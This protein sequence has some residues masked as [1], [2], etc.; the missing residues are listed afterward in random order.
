MSNTTWGVVKDGIIIPDTA[1]PEGTR[2]EIVAHDGPLEIP[3]ELRAEFD[4]WELASS[5]ALD[6][7]E[8][9]A[10]QEVGNAQ[11]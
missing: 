9:H 3:A 7:V 11:G 10:T 5:Q 4:A 8:C 6:L 1:L 2:V